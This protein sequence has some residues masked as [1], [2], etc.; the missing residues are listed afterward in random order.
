MMRRPEASLSQRATGSRLRRD[1]VATEPRT[2]A[3]VT[4]PVAAA[5]TTDDIPDS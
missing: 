5:T 2:V 1:S 3:T 4:R